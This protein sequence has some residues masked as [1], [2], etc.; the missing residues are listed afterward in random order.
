MERV[1]IIISHLLDCRTEKLGFEKI[2][3]K[4]KNNF[5]ILFSFCRVTIWSPSPKGMRSWPSEPSTMNL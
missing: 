1:A 2:C 5:Q 4:L 3:L